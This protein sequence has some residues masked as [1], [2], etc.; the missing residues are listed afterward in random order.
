MD[1]DTPLSRF[2]RSMAIDY[3]KWHD[4]IGYDL[5]ALRAASPAER[6]A[7]EL[8]L[9]RRSPLDWRDIEALAALDTARARD[10]LRAAMRVGDAELRSAVLRHAPALIPDDAR[11][12]S[13]VEALGS[14]RFYG[15][16]TQ[17]LDQVAEFHP[18]AVVDALFR[19][20]LAREGDVAVHFAAMLAYIHGKAAEPF[21]MAQRP[22]FLAF[23]T[24]RRDEREA[25][26]RALCERLGVSASPY[27]KA[28]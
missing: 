16:L 20:A 4:G 19:G 5:E 8:M 28:T 10:A 13:L 3:E 27:L 6:D 25:A 21:D 26:L 23:N 11:T 18:A 14:A 15:G 2:E 1:A 12:V 7:I 9:L 24:D 22:L 17:T